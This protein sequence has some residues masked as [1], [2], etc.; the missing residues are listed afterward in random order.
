MLMKWRYISPGYFKKNL[1][2]D[3]DNFGLPSMSANNKYSHCILFS[4]HSKILLM[5]CPNVFLEWCNTEVAEEG[6]GESCQ[7]NKESSIKAQLS[8]DE[9]RGKN[10]PQKK[11]LADP[12]APVVLD[13]SVPNVAA[14]AFILH[15]FRFK[16]GEPVKPQPDT[17]PSV[18]GCHGEAFVGT[19]TA[20]N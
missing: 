19:V 13:A 9:T 1:E 7:W 12:P 20:L 5:L 2:P 8:E 16:L 14:P 6:E 15:P 17:S 11:N 10:W 3:V 18:R 4:C